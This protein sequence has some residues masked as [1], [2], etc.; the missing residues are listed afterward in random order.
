[1][2]RVVYPSKTLFFSHTCSMGA[3]NIS[4]RLCGKRPASDIE[5]IVLGYANGICDCHSAQFCVPC[6]VAG[7]VVQSHHDKA[8]L[9]IAS[10][11]IE[12]RLR[13][14]VERKL[15]RSK[16]SQKPKTDA[17]DA[18]CK[19]P[20]AKYHHFATRPKHWQRV[21]ISNKTKAWWCSKSSLYAT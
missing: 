5:N 10:K 9:R 14:E 19:Q 21:M 20:Y 13:T 2:N 18:G 7:R 6:V 15:R 16:Q 17:A 8:P 11:Q 1:M 4:Q 3:I 12:F